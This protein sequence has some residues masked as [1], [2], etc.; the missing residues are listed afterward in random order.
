MLSDSIACLSDSPQ[1][2]YTTLQ[3]LRT[4]DAWLLCGVGSVVIGGGNMLSTNFGQIVQA[5]GASE[6]FV[7]TVVTLF[8][9]GNLLG[10]LVATIVSDRVLAFRGRPRPWIAAGIAALMGSA[11]LVLLLAGLCAAGSVGQ[12]ALLALGSVCAGIAFGSMWPHLVV[13][14]SELFG[15]S[16]L[17]ANYLFFDGGCGA[18]GT[19][20]LANLLPT[21]F[22]SRAATDDDEG[23]SGAGS[24]PDLTNRTCA[25]SSSTC[26]GAQCFLPTHSI[27]AGL[28]LLAV[29]ASAVIA[30]RSAG[31]YRQ[32]KRNA[33]LI[34]RAAVGAREGA[35]SAVVGGGGASGV[36]VPG[37]T[38]GS[39]PT[40][41][42]QY[43]ATSAAAMTQPLLLGAVAHAPPPP[44]LS[45]PPLS[46]PPSPAPPSAYAGVRSAT[47]ASFSPRH[48]REPS[49]DWHAIP[50]VD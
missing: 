22:Y 1:V 33:D 37:A 31:L 18:V 44:P 10:R 40:L 12:A 24:G 29:V 20:L 34:A 36:L 41:S 8:S 32:I 9:T 19:L 28:C 49:L 38:E 4:P 27:I 39:K 25:G 15:S 16:H 30:R 11:Q 13:L 42:L 23:G 6:A 17:A 45:K 2:S 50:E 5:C 7:P 47:S 35:T 21:F 48:S 26:L 14:A 3:M 46:A 43:G